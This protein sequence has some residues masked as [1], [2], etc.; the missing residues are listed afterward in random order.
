MYIHLVSLT[1]GAM[2]MVMVSQLDPAGQMRG[3]VTTLSKQRA[4]LMP[5]SAP[6]VYL[7]R[8]EFS[9][10]GLGEIGTGDTSHR[11][12]KQ[13]LEETVEQGYARLVAMR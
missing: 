7:K 10:L 12:Y 2:R 3:L 9:G 11:D 1:K 8:D 6:I 4:Q 13:L 5:V